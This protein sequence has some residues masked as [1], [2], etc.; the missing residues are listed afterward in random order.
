MEEKFKIYLYMD[1]M[2]RQQLMVQPFIPDTQSKEYNECY[3]MAH[4][5]ITDE[6]TAELVESKIA[7]VRSSLP[8]NRDNRYQPYYPSSSTAY[9]GYRTGA[10]HNSNTGNHPF[11]NKE[12]Q[13]AGPRLCLRC[14]SKESHISINC[15]AKH[16]H[17]HPDRKTNVSIKDKRL[18][19]NSDGAA[20][21]L[22]FNLQGSCAA[23]PTRHP[24]HRCSLCLVS[25][26]GAAQCSRV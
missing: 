19:Y 6:H 24:P 3:A 10:G 8:S 1:I 20:V 15:D 18:V 25:Y 17:N 22:K 4:R 12:G 26:H 5:D 16:I 14:G 2:M 13:S 7:A 9:N 21:C 11:R 23:D